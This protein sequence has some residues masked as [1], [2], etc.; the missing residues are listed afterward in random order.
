MLSGGTSSACAM[1]GTAVFKM[2]VSNDSMKKPTATNHGSSRLAVSLKGVLP[3]AAKAS[4]D[5]GARESRIDDALRLGNQA[6]QMGF[7]VKALGVNLVNVLGSRR[8]RSE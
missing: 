5:S 1:A 8:P 4:A 3:P 6:A 7:V 2:V